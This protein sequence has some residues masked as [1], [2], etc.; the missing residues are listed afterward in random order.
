MIDYEKSKNILVLFPSGAGGAF[1]KTIL[2]LSDDCTDIFFNK[3]SIDEKIK[4]YQ[5]KIPNG[6]NF[7]LNGFDHIGYPDWENCLLSADES[8]AYVHHGHITELIIPSA[9]DYFSKIKNLYV[10]IGVITDDLIRKFLEKRMPNLD[11][12]TTEF[13]YNQGDKIF[14]AFY[15]AKEIYQIPLSDLF[16]KETL[17]THV[18]NITKL[19]KL[20]DIDSKEIVNLHNTWI[21]KVSKNLQN[22]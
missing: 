5:T 1:F 13:V 10:V 2:S 15:P 11:I 20:T 9:V 7:H 14:P 16:E 8:V 6:R 19:F 21:K 12:S 4:L 18:N 17:L 3:K 22:L